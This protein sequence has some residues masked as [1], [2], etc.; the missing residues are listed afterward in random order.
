MNKIGYSLDE[1]NRE[2]LESLLR[3]YKT[4]LEG[5]T[6]GGSEYWHEPGRCAR[7]VKQTIKEYRNSEMELSE[8]IHR[9]Q[10]VPVIGWLVRR[11]LKSK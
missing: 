4:S 10:E 8:Q 1:Y 3:R 7:D 2:E 9:I 11:I 5:L 6:V